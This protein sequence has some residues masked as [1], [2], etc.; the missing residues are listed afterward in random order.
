MAATYPIKGRAV[1]VKRGAGTP[2]LIA[3]ARTKS[4]SINGSPIDVT[5]DDDDAVR[6]LM[7]EPGEITVEI[8][9]FGVIQSDVLR[10][11]ALSASDRVEL[12]HFELPGSVGNGQFAGQF[13]LASY[14]ETGEYQGAATFEATFQSAGAVTYTAPT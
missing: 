9:I 11:E 14:T 5:N 4:L 10:A 12:T 3:G 6:K 13:F 1:K 2:T 8:S 7:S